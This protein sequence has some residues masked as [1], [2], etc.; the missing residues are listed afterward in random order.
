MDSNDIYAMVVE[1]TCEVLPELEDH[2][3]QP[4]DS[5]ES[6]GANSMDRAE[7]VMMALERLN[8]KI[9]RVETVG[10]E[11]IGELAELFLDKMQNA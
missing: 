7:I 6:L 3:F 4:S 9:P 1:L 2:Q 11:N 5:L 8:L 10:P